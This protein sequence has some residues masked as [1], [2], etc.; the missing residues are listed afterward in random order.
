[1]K[2]SFLEPIEQYRFDLYADSR[3]YKKL[4]KTWLMAAGIE[5]I[6]TPSRKKVSYV[7]YLEGFEDT[8]IVVD[9]EVIETLSKHIKRILHEEDFTITMLYKHMKREGFIP[10]LDDDKYMSGA[11]FRKYAEPIR[12]DIVASNPSA[13]LRRALNMYKAGISKH[14]IANK[15]K[16][17]LW[18]L[19]IH[20]AKVYEA[21]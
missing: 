18:E 3:C 11:L 17:K 14:A 20:I 15:L 6:P 5:R 19:N 10:R 7:N 8:E 13:K 9:M 21:A 4:V 12:D 16:M 1:M 2:S